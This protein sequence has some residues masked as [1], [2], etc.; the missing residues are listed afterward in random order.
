MNYRHAFHAGNHADVFKHVLLIALL[1]AMRRKPAPFAVLDT[2]AGRGR[3]TMDSGEARRTAEAEG[4]VKR[5]LSAQQSVEPDALVR[6][7]E[8]LRALNPDGT[9]RIY[10]GS[11]LLIAKM[12]RDQDRLA[13]CEMQPV[14]AAALANVFDRESRVAVHQRDGY[15]AISAL[16]PLK[17]GGKAIAR[18]LVLIDPPYE[19]QD[20]EFDHAI[21]ALKGG[22]ARVPQAVFALWYPIKQRRTL[23]NFLRRA[24]SLPA[25]DSW[26]AELL[27][28]PDDSP[29]RMNGSGLLVLNPPWQL[30]TEVNELLPS[31]HAA[32][33]EDGAS[34]RLQWLK[35][36]Q[37]P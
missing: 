16:L 32:L 2:H 12:L 25:S 24:S 11:P 23:H 36:G 30:D 19:A 4:G 8:I 5:L 29:L 35:G 20:A 14:E 6:Y 37:V 3:Y 26:I 9:L 28:R 31:L 33:G 27:I 15:A 34:T 17:S 22:L 21:A 18:T 10:P 7:R 1:Q 13:C